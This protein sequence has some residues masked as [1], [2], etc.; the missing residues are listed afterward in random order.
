MG[1]T[2]PF[3]PLLLDT[4]PLLTNTVSASPPV[5]L[6]EQAFTQ[7]NWSKVNPISL[8]RG[9]QR[10]NSQF[11]LSLPLLDGTTG[12]LLFEGTDFR[13]NVLGIPSGGT[14]TKATFSNGSG[15]LA[16]SA[17]LPTSLPVILNE[18]AKDYG[19]DGR[20]GEITLSFLRS[21]LEPPPIP[22]LLAISPLQATQNEGN[23]G[24]RAFT[25]LVSRTGEINR[26]STVQWSLAGS[27]PNPT[28]EADF[29]GVL[30][31]TLSF[32][33]GQ[34]SRT[35]TVNVAGDRAVEGN[36]SFAVT[37]SEPSANT[38]LTVAEATGSI[39]NDDTTLA[40]AP[41]SAS[42]GEGLTGSRAFSF[43]VTRTGS[44]SGT[45]SVRW[46]AAGSGPNPASGADDFTGATLG[47]LTFAPGQASGTITL[48]VKGDILRE[49]NETFRLT[50]SAPT[51]ATLG[52]SSAL[53]TILNDDWIGDLTANT[54]VGTDL[55]DF[56]DGAGN[57][58]TLT[59]KGGNDVFGF[60]FTQSPLNQPDRISDF[61]FGAD[62][63]DLFSPTG[64]AL[65]TPLRFSRAPDNS[66]AR[67][68]ADLT[69][70]LFADAN[71]ALAGQ[72]ALGINSAVLVSSTNAAIAGTYILVNNGIAGR[73]TNDDLLI[74]LGQF[75]GTLPALGTIP[76]GTVFL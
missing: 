37:L 47:T 31:G 19:D 41:L 53:G 13:Y 20:L 62:K 64:S 15:I 8:Q 70:A 1:D 18:V 38:T 5:D 54:L 36:E 24:S 26:Q 65:P 61:A 4:F 10:T 7:I 28:N 74:R 35:L 14:V 34:T 68:L 21:R 3:P 11:S 56:I 71:G 9:S 32:D 25:F 58:D 66:T 60:R 76:P 42:Q 57:T 75:S 22:S 67:T 43:S 59:G 55:A 16:Q 52:T 17:F 33:A 40:I 46:S 30:A 23:A 69:K 44:L 48:N 63:L 73:S 51:G 12:T 72:Q 45:S 2:P 27:S 39:L 49:A 29:T 6:W 50:L